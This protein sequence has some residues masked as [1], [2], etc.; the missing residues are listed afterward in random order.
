MRLAATAREPRIARSPEETGRP[1][2]LQHPRILPVIDFFEHEDEWF[3]VFAR[4]PEAHPLHEIISSIQKDYRAPYSLTEF[5]ALSAGVTDGLA[6]I[7]KAGFV[8]R[9]LGTHNILVDSHSYVRLADLGWK[10][11]YGDSYTGTQGKPRTRPR[12]RLR[13]TAPVPDPTRA[14]FAQTLS[15]I[16]A[17]N[18][19]FFRATAAPESS[20]T[21]SFPIR[22]PARARC[23][24]MSTPRA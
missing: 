10:R 22:C 6:A 7:H 19:C 23:S 3:S 1:A 2:D 11:N 9:T 20:N 21:A 16:D 15:R 8:H 13:I 24:S 4:I 17:M 12:S 18:A 5:V 14:S